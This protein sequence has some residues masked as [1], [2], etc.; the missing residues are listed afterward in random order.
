MLC[1]ELMACRAASELNLT[2]SAAAAANE[3][4]REPRDSFPGQN[5]LNS[6]QQL[7]LWSGKDR[8]KL[9]AVQ[10]VREHVG[11]VI[12]RLKTVL[13]C[14]PAAIVTFCATRTTSGCRNRSQR[15]CKTPFLTGLKPI[16]RL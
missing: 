6:E 1:L 15:R 11:G 4:N 16:D 3:A 8:D 10:W 13:L 9:N 7:L 12:T 2:E 14:Q 5:V